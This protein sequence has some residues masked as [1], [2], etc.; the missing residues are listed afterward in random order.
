MAQ[1]IGP[2]LRKFW[3]RLAPLPG[4]KWLFSRFIGL[5][6]PYSGSIH[7]RVEQLRPGFGE[8]VLHEHRGLFAQPA[9]A[10]WVG[11]G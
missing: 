7:A 1:S 10:G 3:Q 4:G 8:V 2:T 9:G 6:A 11:A 5:T